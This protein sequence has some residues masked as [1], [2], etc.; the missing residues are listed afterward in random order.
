MS[1]SA[2]SPPRQTDLSASQRACF[3]AIKGYFV[4]TGSM[5]TLEDL[6][7]ALG[8]SSRSGVLGLLRQ[9]E[10]RGRIARVPL[11]ARG[12]RLLDSRE[13]PHCRQRLAP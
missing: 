1:A 13:C 2:S 8:L 3:D 4:R 9:L 6:R 10:K 5:P 11:R 7:L 12:I